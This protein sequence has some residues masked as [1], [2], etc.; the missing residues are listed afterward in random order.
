MVEKEVEETPKGR[1]EPTEETEEIQLNDN[2]SHTN[3]ASG[4]HY[5]ES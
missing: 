3:L 4:L 1:G 2:P 5:N